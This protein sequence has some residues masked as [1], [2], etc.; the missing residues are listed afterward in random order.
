MSFVFMRKF[1]RCIKILTDGAHWDDS[2]NVVKIAEKVIRPKNHLPVC[3]TV[4]GEQN[5]AAPIIQA[6]E[7]LSDVNTVDKTLEGLRLIF[8]G[9]MPA[10][11]SAGTAWIYIAGIS[12]TEG[13]FLNVGFTT[14]PRDDLPAYEFID[15]GKPFLMNISQFDDSMLSLP[16]TPWQITPENFSRFSVPFAEQQRAIKT[17]G[18]HIKV[19][20]HWIGGFLQMTTVDQTGVMSEVLREWPEDTIGKPIVIKEAA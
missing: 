1:D 4:V 9:I 20:C 3:M 7:F 6:F 14:P 10:Q 8:K 13:P 16:I 17:V 19:P 12:E 2:G 18:Q 5:A 11:Q 15:T